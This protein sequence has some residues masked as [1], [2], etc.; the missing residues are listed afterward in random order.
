ML[1]PVRIHAPINR[2]CSIFSASLLL[3]LF[4]QMTEI[5][6]NAGTSTIGIRHIRSRTPRTIIAPCGQ[7]DLGLHA[8]RRIMAGCVQ[9]ERHC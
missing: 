9:R 8:K 5:F 6:T 3:S 4:L 2:R 7:A 1:P